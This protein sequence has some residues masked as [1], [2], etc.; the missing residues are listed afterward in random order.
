MSS[1]K[2][3]RGV[4]SGPTTSAKKTRTR[5]QVTVA[6]FNKWRSDFEREHQTL[7]WLRSGCGRGAVGVARGAV[8][9]RFRYAHR[10]GSGSVRYLNFLSGGTVRTF[11]EWPD[12]TSALIGKWTAICCGVRRVEVRRLGLQA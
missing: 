9:V 1:R 10:C 5:R 11:G 4:G 8:E 7:A 6:T 3:S 2:R 12:K